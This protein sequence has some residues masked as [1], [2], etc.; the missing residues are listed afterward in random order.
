MYALKGVIVHEGSLQSGHYYTY[1]RTTDKLPNDCQHTA[2][3][4]EAINIEGHWYCANDNNIIR[5][6]GVKNALPTRVEKSSGYLLFYEQ[7]QSQK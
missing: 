4:D 2:Y 1:L 6:S 3:C 7:L 5:I